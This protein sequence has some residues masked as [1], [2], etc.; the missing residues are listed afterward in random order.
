MKLPSVPVFMTVT[1][2]FDVE[3]KII[4]SCRDGKIYIFK[5]VN[6]VPKLCIELSS[7]PVGMIRINKNIVVGCMDET[8]QCISDK[9]CIWCFNS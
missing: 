6:V 1:G 7:Q 4:A 2:M 3:Y 8:L 5:R 9:V